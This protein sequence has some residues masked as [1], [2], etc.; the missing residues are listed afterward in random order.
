MQFRSDYSLR[1]FYS[2]C[3]LCPWTSR[4]YNGPAM[5]GFAALWHAKDHPD[6]DGL[7]AVILEV[8]IQVE[9]VT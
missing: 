9:Y 3:V 7:L 4:L 1:R 8:E 2:H 5:A 6:L